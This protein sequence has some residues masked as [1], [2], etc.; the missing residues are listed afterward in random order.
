MG[1]SHALHGR[2][3]E[4]SKERGGWISA[5]VLVREGSRLREAGEG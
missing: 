3:D 1:D 4:R 2:K 5:S